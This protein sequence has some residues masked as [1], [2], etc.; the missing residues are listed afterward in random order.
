MMANGRDVYSQGRGPL[1]YPGIDYGAEVPAPAPSRAPAQVPNARTTQALD[2]A[3]SDVVGGYSEE[4][5]M[6]PAPSMSPPAPVEANRGFDPT[7]SPTNTRNE[8]IWEN[9]HAPL[10]SLPS[11]RPSPSPSPP[12]YQSP[13]ETR[14][15]DLTDIAAPEIDA[16]V[17]VMGTDLG[18]SVTDTVPGIGEIYSAAQIPYNL[19]AARYDAE[20]GDRDGT[21]DHLARVPFN[22]MGAL[23]GASEALGAIDVGLAIQSAEMRALGVEGSDQLPSSIEDIAAMAAVTTTNAIFGA[24][25]TNWIADGNQPQGSRQG[26]ITAGMRGLGTI[27]GPPGQFLGEL[28]GREGTEVAQDLGIGPDATRGSTTGAQ[29]SNAARVGQDIHNA[30]TDW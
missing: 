21:I 14:D 9:Q 4:P 19:E 13:S 27:A 28:L 7:C 24:D 18:R 20:T 17:G 1:Q 30:V 2:A 5:S 26:E 16:I 6:S 29:P 25:D 22:V 3:T 11:L 15:A 8:E 12:T 10:P 23:P